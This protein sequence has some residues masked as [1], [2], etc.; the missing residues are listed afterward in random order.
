MTENIQ[1]G[2]KNRGPRH[3]RYGLAGLVFLFCMLL[4]TGSLLQLLYRYRLP[5]DGWYMVTTELDDSSWIYW[6]NLVGAP[7][8][9]KQGDL[10]LSVEGVDLTGQASMIYNQPPPNW[11][12]GQAVQVLVQRG[13]MGVQQGAQELEI[14]LPVVNWTPAAWLAAV[15]DVDGLFSLFGAIALAGIGFFTFFR[16]PELPSARLLL[17]FSCSVAAAVLSGTLPDGLSVQFDRLAFGLT[18]FFS[19]IIFGTLIAPSLLTFSLY[20]PRPKK[21]LERYPFL[22]LAP[23]LYGL[24]LF[25]GLGFLGFPAETGWLSS[26]A[27]FMGV[28]VSLLHSGFT[29]RDAVSQAQFR[30]AVGSLVIG[31]LLFLNVFPAAFGWVTNDF[32]LEVLSATSGLALTVIGL[33]LSV[34]I[35]RYRLFDIDLII[36]RTLLYSL[37]TVVLA[38]VYSGSVVLLQQV[39]EAIIGQSDSPLVIVMSTLAIAALFNPLRRRL[40][41]IID[42]RFYR[43]TYDPQTTLDNFSRQIRDELQTSKLCEDIL[44]TVQAT[45]E[46]AQTTLWLLEPSEKH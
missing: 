25:I 44:A 7:S 27:M 8:D 30:W 17:I 41:A 1:A 24:L 38:L 9:L 22:G 45:L 10:L 29:Q 33:G 18:G 40:Q 46:P 5:T 11:Q 2:Q 37:V 36:R 34:A 39:F 32:Y 12:A 35:L 16:R 13:G 42:G 19:Y 15:T 4:L 23:Y 28:L 14:S 6:R 21:L 31:I 26:M 3:D 43:R 20:F